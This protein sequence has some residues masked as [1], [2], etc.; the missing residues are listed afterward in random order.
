MRQLLWRLVNPSAAFA[1]IV[2]RTLFAQ[3]TAA[4]LR[5]MACF[6]RLSEPEIVRLAASGCGLQLERYKTLFREGAAAFTVY[7]LL[8]G[9]VEHTSLVSSLSPGLRLQASDCSS[10][11]VAHRAIL[12]SLSCVGSINL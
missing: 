9:T 6:A 5:G 2:T 4:V 11:G 7:V 12:G 8:E 10:L 3:R 1:H